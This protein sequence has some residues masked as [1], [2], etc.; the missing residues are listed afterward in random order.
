MLAT[1][2]ESYCSQIPPAERKSGMPLSVET[3]APAS[4]TQGR[5]VR[6]RSAGRAAVTPSS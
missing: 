6:I 4:T 1:S 3:P 5:C 2:N